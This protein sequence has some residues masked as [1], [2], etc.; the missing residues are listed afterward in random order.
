MH[1]QAPLSQFH[2]HVRRQVSAQLWDRSQRGNSDVRWVVGW[3]VWQCAEKDVA[4]CE[5]QR[6]AVIPI[7]EHRVR[8]LMRQLDGGGESGA[9]EAE[10]VGGAA[11]G[12]GGAVQRGLSAGVEEA[13][14]A[15]GPGTQEAR[16]PGS[17]AGEE[18]G[19]EEDE[20][21]GAGR[22]SPLPAMASAPVTPRGL[23]EGEEGEDSPPRS[24]SLARSM[25]GSSTGAGGSSRK[26]KKKKGR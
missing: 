11:E 5:Q 8:T 6:E 1:M 9:Q 21:E 18:E 24:P 7:L 20:E 3:W 14:T 23:R 16:I 22:Q 4:E 10:A 2:R 26:K 12:G 15:D 19:D 13:K 17:A 25:S